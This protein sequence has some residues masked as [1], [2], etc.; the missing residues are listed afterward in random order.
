MAKV[1][2]DVLDSLSEGLRDS[3]APKLVVES[4]DPGP[5]GRLG[6]V[7][8][9]D[10]Q[11]VS[12]LLWWDGR[13]VTSVSASAGSSEV[14]VIPDGKKTLRKVVASALDQALRESHPTV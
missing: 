4:F 5:D 2:K 9:D 10:S 14:V 7:A 3:F 13:E 6:L 12:I 1:A 8:F 11:R